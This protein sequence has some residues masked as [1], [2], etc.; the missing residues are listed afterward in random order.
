ME[1]VLFDD[2]QIHGSYRKLRSALS[3]CIAPV[4]D[5]NTATGILKAPQ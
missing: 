4:A 5:E 2:E 1:S 3:G